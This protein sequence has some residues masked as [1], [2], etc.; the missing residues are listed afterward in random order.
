MHN[1]AAHKELVKKNCRNRRSLRQPQLAAPI[2]AT[3]KKAPIEAFLYLPENPL[4]Y[5]NT[6]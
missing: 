6:L 3:V 4:E 1:D 5:N 2:A